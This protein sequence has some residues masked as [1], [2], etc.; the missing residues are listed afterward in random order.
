MKYSPDFIENYLSNKLAEGDKKRFEESLKL[1]EGLRDE[2]GKISMVYNALDE[3]GA[4]KLMKRFAEI[5]AKLNPF[6]SVKFESK[7]YLRWAASIALIAL[8]SIWFYFSGSI[9]NQDLFIA[10][11]SAYPN[12]ESPISRSDQGSDAV[13]LAYEKGDYDK[14]YEG[15]EVRVTTNKEDIASWFYLG[16]CAIELNKLPEAENALDMV[17]NSSNDKYREQAHWYLA[18][19]YLKAGDESMTIIVLEDI[20]KSKST[21]TQRAKELLSK[22]Y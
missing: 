21:Y 2:V 3:I 17:V 10:N 11:Y 20:K 16:I 12:V 7:I 9:S 5:E 6:K 19:S 13:W 4:K 1:D 15:F 22:L 18:L 14:A 8:L